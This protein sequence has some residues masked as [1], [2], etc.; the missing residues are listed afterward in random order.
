MSAFRFDIYFLSSA[1]RRPNRVRCAWGQSLGMGTA[2]VSKNRGTVLHVSPRKQQTEGWQRG[3]WVQS[4]EMCFVSC[5]RDN[6]HTKLIRLRSTVY[7]KFP[8]KSVIMAV[9]KPC[10]CRK[11]IL[12]KSPHTRLSVSILDLSVTQLSGAE[13]R[14]HEIITGRNRTQFF[15]FMSTSCLIENNLFL[16]RF[17]NIHTT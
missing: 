13:K 14:Q 12:T 3:Q 15:S 11:H 17:M 2:G 7:Y 4:Q 8:H 10:F 6:L 5:S 1:T 16:C 9:S